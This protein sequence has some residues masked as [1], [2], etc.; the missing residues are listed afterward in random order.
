MC[1]IGSSDA[2]SGTKKRQLSRI[3]FTCERKNQKKVN[4]KIIN[5]KKLL[6][7]NVILRNNCAKIEL[8][9]NCLLSSG[10]STA[11]SQVSMTLP[12]FVLEWQ[13]DVTDLFL[14][15]ILLFP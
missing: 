10:K 13:H 3:V 7:G 6:S 5:Y 8:P 1:S 12:Y 14:Q 2:T 15:E 4:Y 11:L 9:F